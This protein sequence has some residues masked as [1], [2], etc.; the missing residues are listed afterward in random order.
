MDFVI[1]AIADRLDRTA[2]RFR[3]TRFPQQ[4]QQYREAAARVRAGLSLDEAQD[5]ELRLLDWSQSPFSGKL[6][7]W[8]AAGE[9]DPPISPLPTPIPQPA[10]TPPP[11]PTPAPA[12]VDPTQPVPAPGPT[13]VPDGPSPVDPVPADPTPVAPAAGVDMGFI[14]TSEGGQL[15]DG[16]VPN[17]TGSQSGV[18]VGT[19]VDIGQLSAAQLDNLDIPQ[20]LK[21]QL[22]PYVGLKGQ[23]AVDALAATP[24]NIDSADA[25]TLDREVLDPIINSV[26][27]SY[28]SSGAS[29][30]FA[31]LPPEVQTVLA[32]LAVQYGSD[33]AT[34]TPNFWADVTTGNWDAALAELQD[35]GDSTQGRRDREAALLQQ[36]INRGALAAPKPSP[37]NPIVVP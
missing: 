6:S 26:Q 32:D 30:T 10:P 31:S 36:A 28:D 15:L 25:E 3:Y 5:L 33:L 14:S 12:P 13:P 21:D 17:P 37:S 2:D 9:Y 22:A 19:G 16:Y 4:E 23:D 35:F 29:G 11:D 1:A 20:S 34:A 27:A 18:T 8:A 7:S 24:L